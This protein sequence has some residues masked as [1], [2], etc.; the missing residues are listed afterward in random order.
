[1]VKIRIEIIDD[2][3]PIEPDM[4][5]NYV[6]YQIVTDILIEHKKIKK[7][8]IEFIKFLNN[9]NAWETIKP[10]TPNIKI[11]NENTLK[12]MV[13]ISIPDQTIESLKNKAE[14]MIS[15]IDEEYSEFE[16]LSL[17]NNG[18]TNMIS[19]FFFFK[20]ALFQKFIRIFPF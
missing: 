7:N 10:S 19:S 15:F 20:T 5:F 11:T 16:E 6:N 8:Q 14:S 4:N 9:L 2:P 12:L 1:M 18:S 17:S 13:Q 3:K